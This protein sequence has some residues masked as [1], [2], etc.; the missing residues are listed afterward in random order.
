MTLF[1][2]IV[3]PSLAWLALR[4]AARATRRGWRVISI[5]RFVIWSLA[6]VL[7]FAPD[8][9]MPLARLFGVVRGVDLVVYCYMIATS[10]TTLYFYSRQDRLERKIVK[11]TR[12]LAL[13]HVRRGGSAPKSDGLAEETT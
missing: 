4:E 6:A 12:D 7:A 9:T 1:Q 5:I 3:G 11:L 2:W 8:I 10:A 13:D